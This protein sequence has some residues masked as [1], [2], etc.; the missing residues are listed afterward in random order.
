MQ[1][2]KMK[3]FVTVTLRAFAKLSILRLD[4]IKMKYVKKNV[5]FHLSPMLP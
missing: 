2:V 3:V 5:H 1:L 4:D